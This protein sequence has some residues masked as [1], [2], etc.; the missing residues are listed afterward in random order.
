MASNRQ[1]LESCCT[2]FLY[3]FAPNNETFPIITTRKR[4]LGQSNV[5]TS[6]CQ[7]FS[8]QGGGV[9]FPTCITGHMSGELASMHHW[10]HDGGGGWFLSLHQ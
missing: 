5:F 3:R 7:L 1:Y 8:Q 10:S 9:G 2:N 6:M 4:S